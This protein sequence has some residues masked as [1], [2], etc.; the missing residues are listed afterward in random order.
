MNNW[1]CLKTAAAEPQASQETY[2]ELL[3]VLLAAGYSTLKTSTPPVEPKP[4]VQKAE[5]NTFDPPSGQVG[6]AAALC[7]CQA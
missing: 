3:Q 6:L 1:D 5:A 7:S 4:C 2:A